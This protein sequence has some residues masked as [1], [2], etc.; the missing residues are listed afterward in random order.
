MLHSHYHSMMATHFL[1][2]EDLSS[3]CL[4]GVIQNIQRLYPAHILILVSF[5]TFLE[6][7]SGERYQED[8]LKITIFNKFVRTNNKNR[9]DLT[10]N[11][12]ALIQ[13]ASRPLSN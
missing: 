11:L 13:S 12:R 6:E 4:V 2:S 10:A 1:Q 7:I 5:V 3:V 8:S 9:K